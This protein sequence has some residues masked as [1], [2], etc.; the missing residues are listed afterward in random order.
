[1]AAKNSEYLKVMENLFCEYELSSVKL[2]E[3]ISVLSKEQ[4]KHRSKSDE[5]KELYNRIRR[6]K[7]CL[8]ET[9]SWQEMVKK[10]LVAGGMND[11][12]IKRLLERKV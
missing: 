7:R 6:L 10:Y 8:E 1:M 5:Y 3:R 4:S 9:R 12:E 11:E 2:E